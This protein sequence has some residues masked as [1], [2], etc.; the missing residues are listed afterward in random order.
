MSP[1]VP[2]TS[3][4][5]AAKARRPAPRADRMV[6][7]TSKRTRRTGKLTGG[8]EALD[9]RFDL[10]GRAPAAKGEAERAFHLLACAPDGAQHGRRRPRELRAGGSGRSGHPGEVEVEQDA[11]RLDPSQDQA[12]VVR[13]TLRGSPRE[14]AARDGKQEPLDEPVTQCLEPRR[15]AV[16]SLGADELSGH[17][18]PDHRGQV[19]RAGAV[20]A[21]LPAAQEDGSE[22]HAGAYPEGPRARRPVDIVARHGDEVESQDLAGQRNAPDRAH[23]V[24]VQWH[25]RAARDSGDLADR[26]KRPHLRA[27]RADGDEGRVRAK[28]PTQAVRVHAPLRVDGQEGDGGPT[29]LELAAG[30]E[31]RHVLD[32]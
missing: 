8:R 5:A 28:R 20:A 24:D 21:L 31:Y 7:S 9:D 23:R 26:L 27:G 1:A 22:A 25:A 30:I 16:E 19:L 11:V 13:E 12:C 2:Y 14:A 18:H 15:L 4:R 3:M 6:P 17:P 29:L 10:G 32:G